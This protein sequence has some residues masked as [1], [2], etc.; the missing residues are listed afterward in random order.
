MGNQTLIKGAAIAAPQFLDVGAAAKAGSQSMAGI[1]Q[2]RQLERRQQENAQ[3]AKV[4]TYLSNMPSG[5]ELSKIP[6]AQQA[7]VAAWSKDMKFRYAEAARNISTMDVGSEEYVEAMGQMDSIK[8]AFVNLNNNLET[9]KANKTEYL[10]SSSAGS[11]SKGNDTNQGNLIAGIYTDESDMIFDENGNMGFQQDGGTV[12]LND[13]PDYFNKD[14]ENADALININSNIYNSGSKLDSTMQN[15]YRQKIL[16]MVRKGGRETA[17]SLATDDL[18]QEGGLGIVDEDLLYNPERQE[19]L[20]NAVVD[21]YMNILNSSAEAGFKKKSDAAAKAA[22]I[23]G[24]NNKNTF[25]IKGQENE[26]D[27]VAYGNLATNASFKIVDRLKELKDLKDPNLSAQD[28]SLKNI[29]SQVNAINEIIGEYN[30]GYVDLHY[31]DG[32][33]YQSVDGSAEKAV[34]EKNDEGTIAQVKLKN[35]SQLVNYIVNN[36]GLSEDDAKMVLK[37][38][39]KKLLNDRKPKNST[40]NVD[41]DVND[42]V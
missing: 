35:T 38:R 34:T 33:Y 37:Q 40:P 23:A 19:D 10:K 6:P 22:A 21:G 41:V 8:S 28:N 39:I 36:S 29:S 31:S 12:S 3:K 27:L 9:F 11:L 5:I 20:E 13:I 26:N 18:I 1:Y 24:K 42:I 2:A 30:E 15:M 32:V 17:L 25:P 16:N 14:F 4:G 7:G